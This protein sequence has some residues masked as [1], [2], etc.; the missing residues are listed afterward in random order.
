MV[1]VTILG[2]PDGLG[3]QGWYAAAASATA[4]DADK[5]QVFYSTLFQGLVI[6]EKFHPS[7][8]LSVDQ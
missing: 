2:F 6:E 7:G 5:K 4:D 8:K 1:K 3:A